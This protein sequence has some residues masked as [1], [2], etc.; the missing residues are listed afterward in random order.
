MAGD[1]EGDGGSGAGG[2]GTDTPE[3]FADRYVLRS[4]AGRGGMAEVWRAEQRGAAGFHRPVGLKR[5]L[6]QFAAKENF[7]KMFIEEARVCAQL[8]HPNIIQIYDFGFER[9]TYFLV[10]EWVEGINLARFFT[11]YRERDLTPP[12]PILTAIAIE[13]L[14][15]LSAAHERLDASGAATPV[16]HRDVTPANILIGLNGVVKLSDFGLARAMDRSRLTDPDVIKGKIAYLS[17]ELTHGAEAS[18]QSDVY[19]LGVTLWQGLTNQKLF[20][21]DN[22]AEVFMAARKADIPRLADLRPDLPGDFTAAI[23]RALARDLDAR[24]STAAE[25][26]ATLTRLLRKSPINPDPKMIARAVVEARETLGLE[27]LSTPMPLR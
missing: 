26:R 19:A 23:D 13:S 22:N 24:W 9:G 21:G 15:A 16:I 4:L 6:P 27:T 1:D 14:K 10:M 20:A 7:V 11:A 25:M 17:P 2:D 12:W 8:M 3:L 5:I 18:P